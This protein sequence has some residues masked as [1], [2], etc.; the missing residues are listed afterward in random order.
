MSVPYSRNLNKI[1]GTT[2]TL[3]DSD[4]S[5]QQA[6]W[7]HFGSCFCSAWWLKWSPKK[8]IVCYKVCCKSAWKFYILLC[9]CSSLPHFQTLVTLSVLSQQGNPS[10]ITANISVVGPAVA[11]CLKDGSTPVKLAAERCLLHVFQLT[12]GIFFCILCLYL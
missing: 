10:I 1:F 7:S 5:K 9:P 6:L 4:R 11:E 3:S 8:G 12:R 2:P